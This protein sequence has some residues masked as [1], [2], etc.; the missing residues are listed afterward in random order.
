MSKFELQNN[1]KPL[2]AAIRDIQ[3]DGGTHKS[4]LKHL[5]A[6]TF[7]LSETYHG[8][9]QQLILL[10]AILFTQARID[11]GY[12]V[13]AAGGLLNRGSTLFQSLGKL[14]IVTTLEEADDA[15]NFK[16]FALRS[17]YQWY[18]DTAFKDDARIV[19]NP[20]CGTDND[21]KE[22]E[23]KLDEIAKDLAPIS[24]TQFTILN[25]NK[26]INYDP[27]AKSETPKSAEPKSQSSSWLSFSM[28]GSYSTTAVESKT[29]E[30]VTAPTL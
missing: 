9:T 8:R 10:G 14:D 5:Q 21:Y 27:N 24:K 11:K 20:L 23:T 28:F 25:S 3:Y 16:A 15:E 22:F 13:S 19:E 2:K 29:V 1:V 17:F 7:K 6:V 30:Q 18:Q 4:H 26:H 12:F